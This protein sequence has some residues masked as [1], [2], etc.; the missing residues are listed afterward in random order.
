MAQLDYYIGAQRGAMSL[1]DNALTTGTAA[2]GTG[3]DF[4]LKIQITNNVT[5]TGVT[6]KDVLLF[7]ELLEKWV[8]SGGL[9]H[10]GA[11][12]PAN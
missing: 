5:A 2:T 4:E 3:V 11:N 10:A 1:K 9:N 12:L 6:R 8:N 7:L